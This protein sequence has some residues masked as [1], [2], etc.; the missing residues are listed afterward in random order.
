MTEEF[1]AELADASRRIREATKGVDGDV[2][3]AALELAL[4]CLPSE[5]EEAGH[6]RAAEQ[7]RDAVIA[8]EA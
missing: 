8:L 1:K 7:I 3:L 4:G 2:L 6:Y 5:L